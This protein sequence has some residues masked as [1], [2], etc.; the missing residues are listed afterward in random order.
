LVPIQVRFAPVSAEKHLAGAKALVDEF[1][2]IGIRADLDGADETVGN[3]IRKAVAQK[4]P[5]VV[6]V[7]DK[8]L[9][10]EDWM[11]RVRGEKDQV[12]MKRSEFEERVREEIKAKL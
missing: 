3:K 1:K 7:G 9:G 12:K 5:Y 11:I 4:I 2:A 8:E 10:G 6:V